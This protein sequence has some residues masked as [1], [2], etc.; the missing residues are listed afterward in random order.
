MDKQIAEAGDLRYCKIQNH[1]RS[2]EQF[3]IPNS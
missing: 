2:Q 3:K 1:R